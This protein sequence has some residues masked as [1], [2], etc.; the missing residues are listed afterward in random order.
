M[1]RLIF[2]T[3][4]AFVLLVV[5][6]A[7]AA[8]AGARADAHE[9]APPA[10]RPIPAPTSIRKIDEYGNIPFGDE[11]ARLDN[12]DIELRG[13]PAAK[14]YIVGYGG[15]RARVGEARRRVERAKRYL[16]AA[17]KID[18]ARLRTIDGG[19]RE[20]L[21]VELYVFPADARPPD[22]SPTVDPEEVIF[23]RTKPGRRPKRR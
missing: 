13:D 11:K 18:P 1:R 9:S 5:A 23:V 22:V 6:S 2:A 21:T 3:A 12:L 15:R 20:N 19:Y 14:G 7:I 10:A 8:H 4:A 16:V 17:R